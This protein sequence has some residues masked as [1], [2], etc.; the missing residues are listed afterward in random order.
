MLIDEAN[1][2]GNRGASVGPEALFNLL[3]NNCCDVFRYLDR[4]THS[5]LRRLH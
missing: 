5:I 3:L 4:L 1:G 2:F